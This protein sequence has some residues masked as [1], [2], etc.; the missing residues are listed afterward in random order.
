[1]KILSAVVL[2]SAVALSGCAGHPRRS[3]ALVGA[4]VGAVGALAVSSMLSSPQPVTQAPVQ[5][6]Q[7]QPVIRCFSRFM[8][9]DYYRNPMY[10][11]VCR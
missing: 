9:Y 4:G 5:V 6:A 7:P 8:G 1:M 3:A 11:E 10:Q 2:V